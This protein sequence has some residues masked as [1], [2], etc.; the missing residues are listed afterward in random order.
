L[1]E[2]IGTTD[3]DIDSFADRHSVLQLIAGL[4]ERDRR[5]LSLRFYDNMTQTQIAEQLGVS[6]MQVSRLLSASLRKLRDALLAEDA[7]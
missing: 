7:E 6:Q 4:P 5:V 2:L 1:S 3:S